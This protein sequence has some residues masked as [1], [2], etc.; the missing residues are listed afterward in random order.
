MTTLDLA[1]LLA[2]RICHDL[3]GSVGA[4]ANGLEVLEE[5][6]GEMR[7]A[8]FELLNRS[9]GE[10]LARLKFF[11]LAFGAGGGQEQVAL[12][13]IRGVAEYPDPE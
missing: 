13:E 6:D 3:V 4:I 2:S 9:V 8:A 10:A 5:D 12:A 11:R 1:S 7:E